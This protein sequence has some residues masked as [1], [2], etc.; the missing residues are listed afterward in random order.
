MLVAWDKS[1]FV[2]QSVGANVVLLSI[3][4]TVFIRLKVISA[5]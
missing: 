4:F 3:I 2:K 5:Y 1:L